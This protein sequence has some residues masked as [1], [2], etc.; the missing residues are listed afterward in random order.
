VVFRVTRLALMGALALP[1]TATA[2]A[3]EPEEAQPA[4]ETEPSSESPPCADW[5]GRA[6]DGN[7]YPLAAAPQ[8]SAAEPAV[9]DNSAT[10]LGADHWQLVDGRARNVVTAGWITALGGLGLDV[11]GVAIGSYELV[12]VGGLGE[13]VGAPM[14]AGGTLRSATALTNQGASVGRAGGYI[15][16]GL[17]GGGLVANIGANTAY[18]LDTYYALILT[19]LGLRVASYASAAAQSGANRRARA[20]LDLLGRRKSAAVK[21]FFVSVTVDG[22]LI[23]AGRF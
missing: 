8:P 4:E 23:A 6:A 7:C 1:P 20:G 14:I 12:L 17:W 10:L 15:A 13:G 19:G 16:W 18:Y 11:A 3:Q 22:R 5:F 2:V 9:D 21:S